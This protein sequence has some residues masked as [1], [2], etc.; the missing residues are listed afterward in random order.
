MI[1]L[2]LSL[3]VRD[4]IEGRAALREV[5]KIVAGTCYPDRETFCDR[6][7]ETYCR[8]Y[9]RRAPRRAHA[10][11]MR[12]WDEDKIDQPRLRGEDPPNVSAGHWRAA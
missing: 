9:W 2:S 8:T 1:G 11:A 5:S 12:L 7:R 3:C 6:L 10:L 4:I